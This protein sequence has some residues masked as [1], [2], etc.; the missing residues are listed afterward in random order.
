M[1]V[2]ESRNGSDQIEDL[3]KLENL[4]TPSLVALAI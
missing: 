1:Y 3:L 2:V 4:L